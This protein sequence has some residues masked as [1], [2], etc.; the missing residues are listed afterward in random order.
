MLNSE[1]YEN[2]LKY[3]IKFQKVEFKGSSDRNGSPK[4]LSL[5]FYCL[6]AEADQLIW[7]NPVRH[8]NN[9][10]INFGYNG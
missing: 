9:N 3:R 4:L 8:Y 7:T 5:F 2:I 6:A 10:K 1:Y